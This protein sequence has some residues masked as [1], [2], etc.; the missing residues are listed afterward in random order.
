MLGFLLLM[1]VITCISQTLPNNPCLD[2]SFYVHALIDNA[3]VQEIK[4]NFMV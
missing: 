2:L 4:S 3:S 1:L